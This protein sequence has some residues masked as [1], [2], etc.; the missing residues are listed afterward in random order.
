MRLVE[1]LGEARILAIL[2]MDEVDTWGVDVARRLHSEGVR[3][4]ECTLDRPGAMAA[5]RTLQEEMGADTLVGAGTVLHTSQV[6]N[7]A[8]MGVDFCVT[9]H[10]DPEVVND[11]LDAGIPII[12]GVMTASEVAAAFRL[13]VPAVKLFPAG[14]LGLGYLRALRAPFGDFPVVPTG[15][16][17]AEDVPGWL[18]AG[19]VCVGLGS[20][21]TGPDGVP[22]SLREVLAE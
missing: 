17:R 8:R 18:E 1:R 14:H 10:L 13:G 9:P 7:L 5:I 20:A 19:A 16:V 21:L 11:A 3:A 12:P 6:A 22:A 4:I 15:G 2:R